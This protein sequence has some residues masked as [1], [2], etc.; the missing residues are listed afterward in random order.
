METKRGTMKPFK[1]SVAIRKVNNRGYVYIGRAN[2]G[3]DVEITT[4]PSAPKI[5]AKT[6]K[7]MEKL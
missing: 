7:E 2:A 6:I 5:T 3:Q 1:M 4:K